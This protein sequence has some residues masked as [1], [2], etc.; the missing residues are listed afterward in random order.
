MQNTGLISGT[1]KTKKT[2]EITQKTW[3]PC[4]GG[5]GTEQGRSTEKTRWDSLSPVEW[6]GHLQWSRPEQDMAEGTQSWFSVTGQLSAGKDGK[7][8]EELATTG[9]LSLQQTRATVDNLRRICRVLPVSSVPLLLL[10]NFVKYSL[11]IVVNTIMLLMHSV[12]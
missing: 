1:K 5:G 8:R 3:N 11:L 9:C 7:G 10:T 12:F 2:P 6:M 4:P